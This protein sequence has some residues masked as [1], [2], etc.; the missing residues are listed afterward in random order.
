MT[1]DD[2]KTLEAFGVKLTPIEI[3]KNTYGININVPFDNVAVY[4]NSNFTKK[5]VV[6]AH[7]CDFLPVHKHGVV[8]QKINKNLPPDQRPFNCYIGDYVVDEA[9]V[10]L[11]D[12]NEEVF[13]FFG[14]IAGFDEYERYSIT[15]VL[16]EDLNIFQKYNVSE[17]SSPFGYYGFF[18][19][20][21]IANEKL[22]ELKANEIGN[23]QM[24]M[25]TISWF[26]L[27]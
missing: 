11:K 1:K 5:V 22:N 14:K 15:S 4:F 13:D 24:K 27:K 19:S 8:P 2:L 3:P 17:Y 12:N 16:K 18:T 23:L 20:L 26:S 9:R 10:I 6:A 25:N 7:I 21:D